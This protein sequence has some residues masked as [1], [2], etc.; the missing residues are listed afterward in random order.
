[1]M[2]SQERHV[3]NLKLDILLAVLS[4][5]RQTCEL[6][7]EVTATALGAA[8]RI[9]GIS[10]NGIASTIELSIV[11]GRI[12]ACVILDTYRQQLMFQGQS[13]L[14]LCALCGELAWIIHPDKKTPVLITKEAPSKH[15][16]NERKQ[17][18]QIQSHKNFSPFRVTRFIDF[19]QEQLCTLPRK[20]RQVW[21]VLGNG[22]REIH[23][24][25]HILHISKEQLIP[26]LNKL[27]ALNVVRYIHED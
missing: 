17:T 20:D 5:N 1:M 26:I 4:A 27:A 22:P 12:H 19:T 10:G 16:R 13:A 7:T 21:M 11:Q 9:K 15:N 25:C 8:K 14:E 18:H 6:W 3:Y 24:L 2:E 23:E